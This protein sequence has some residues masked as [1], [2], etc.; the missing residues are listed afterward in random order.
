MRRAL[1]AAA[2]AACLLGVGG[3]SNGEADAAPSPTSSSSTPSETPS[4]SPS[5]TAVAPT[6]P[7]EAAERTAAGAEAFVRHWFEVLE[8]AYASGDTRHLVTI[9]SPECAS[10]DRF[11]E[12]IVTT[13]SNGGSFRGVDVSVLSSA[14]PTPSDTSVEVQFRL[15][16]ASFAVL[17]SNG[18]VQERFES[19]P[20][21]A[22]SFFLEWHQDRWL[23][24]GIAQSEG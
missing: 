4:A 2:V 20:P 15:E 1:G 11:T 17:N 10:C 13:Y 23:A 7:P 8:Y 3:C 21:A 24:F 9:S 5:P 6:M 12:R 18:E 22:A 16:E 19:S 14:A